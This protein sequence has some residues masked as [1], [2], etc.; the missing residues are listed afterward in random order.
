[1]SE[2]DPFAETLGAGAPHGAELAEGTLIG[3]RYRVVSLLGAG[4]MGQVY[5]ATDLELDQQVALKVLHA[6]SPRAVQRFR[7]EVKLAQRVTH[8][9][10]VRLYDLGVAP[11]FL[12]L[13]MELLEGGPLRARLAAGPISIGEACEIARQVALGLGAAHEAG[14][15]HRDLKPENILVDGKRVVVVDFGVAG[16]HAVEAS[17]IVG[18]TAYMAPEQANGE[19]AT[20][21]ADLYALGLVLHELLSGTVPLVGA[22]PVATALRRMHEDP[23]PPSETRPEVPA[24]LDALVLQLLA[25]TPDARPA[26]AAQVAAALAVW[27]TSTFA[28]RRI[29]SDVASAPT[30]P[31]SAQRPVA[32]TEP[33][34]R[35]VSRR[36]ILAGGAA[37]TAALAGGAALLLG[38]K[39]GLA[40]DPRAPFL[41][42]IAPSPAF[43]NIEITGPALRALAARL[44]RRVARLAAGSGAAPVTASVSGQAGSFGARLAAAG[45]TGEG[46]GATIP[47][48]LDAAAATLVGRVLPRVTPTEADERDRVAWGASST[49]DVVA[50][51]RVEIAAARLRFAEAERLLVAIARPGWVR[52]WLMRCLISDEIDLS[53]EAIKRDARAHAATAPAAEVALLEAALGLLETRPE[54]AR[55]LAP[56][57]ELWVSIM[58]AWALA[59]DGLIDEAFAL[60]SRLTADPETGGLARWVAVRIAHYYE[61]EGRGAIARELAGALEEEPAAWLILA[62]TDPASAPN[63]TR[64]ARTLGA[65]RIP[66]ARVE[67]SQAVNRFDLAAAETAG[68]E[69]LEDPRPGVRLEGHVTL[70]AVD[71]LRGQLVNAAVRKDQLLTVLREEGKYAAAI[72]A[73]NLADD[74]MA[75]GDLGLARTFAELAAELSKVMDR[76]YLSMARSRLAALDVLTGQAVGAVDGDTFAQVIIAEVRGACEPAKATA[77]FEGASALATLHLARCALAEDA[78]QA[79]QLL[80]EVFV[81]TAPRQLPTFVVRRE[82]LLGE[83]FVL[84]GNGAQAEIH[85]RRVVSLWG[86]IPGGNEAARARELLAAMKA[87]P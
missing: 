70:H 71:V 10:V 38:R 87:S 25:R 20:P 62:E 77:F 80:G 64:V 67:A 49:E 55:A 56:S 23:P 60:V 57:P 74:A 41:L 42:E 2:S 78:E 17:A 68:R 45:E 16:E 51:R 34:T 24:E 63:A 26:S 6:P 76:D 44:P 43:G 48:A 33:V 9:N 61:R 86:K 46:N 14:V 15:I 28:P 69:L 73:I 32:T 1:V 7:R 18:T 22:G 12:Y 66:L 72:E 3:G 53:H 27:A 52:P 37:L 82:L 13:T 29:A 35:R 59:Y 84:M 19:A 85:L 39:P 4:G 30:T 21:R 36:T 79:F 54:P 65:G 8:P 5:R 75:R 83:A 40:I 58:R 81:K 50:F 47:D 11:G 31:L